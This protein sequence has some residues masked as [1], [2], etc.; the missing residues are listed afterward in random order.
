MCN[1]ALRHAKGAPCD[2]AEWHSNKKPSTGYTLPMRLVLDPAE[3]AAHGEWL[4]HTPGA[5]EWW[6]FDALSD[7]G[8]YAL[9]CIWFLGNPFSPYYRRA[10]LGLPTDPFRHNALFFALYRDGRLHAYHFTR[11]PAGQ[12]AAGEALPLDLRLGD[13]CLSAGPGEWRLMLSDENANCRRLDAAL[14]FAAPLPVAG[15]PEE[16]APESN[17][18]WLPAAPF[19]RVAGRIVLREEHNP[20]AEEIAFSGNGYHDHNWGRLPF[21]SEIRDWYWARAALDG[22]RAV[23]LYHVRPRGGGRPVSHF[24]LFARGRMVLHDAAPNVRL[25]RPALNAFGTVYATRMEVVSGDWSVGFEFGARLD[26][27]PFYVRALCRATLDGKS[28]SETGE[29]IGE[30]LRP[31]TMSWPLVASAMKARIVER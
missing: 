29:G 25:S 17:H 27:A 13:N 21:A 15:Q 14:T 22:E 10:G 6:Y 26:S 11:F 19:C 4:R 31:R 5:Y 1:T 3:E 30:Y 28:R 23:I 24:L 9:S 7:D 12:V 2:K 16:V 18:F 8:R 20:G